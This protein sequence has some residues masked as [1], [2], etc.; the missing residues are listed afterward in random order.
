MSTT[1]PPGEIQTPSYDA[2]AM[3]EGTTVLS[4]SQTSALVAPTALSANSGSAQLTRRSLPGP[5]RL[6][7]LN[8]ALTN[9]QPKWYQW[10]GA[11]LT[12]VILMATAVA[13]LIVTLP[14]ATITLGGSLLLTAAIGSA[15]IS[16]PHSI[17]WSDYEALLKQYTSPQDIAWIRSQIQ[18]TADPGEKERLREFLAE[19]EKIEPSPP[20]VQDTMSTLR[21]Q[22]ANMSSNTPPSQE[23]IA[24]MQATLRQLEQR[25]GQGLQR[26]T[27]TVP[28]QLAIAS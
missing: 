6:A 22:V 18:N 4:S 7:Q 26:A 5:A 17:L 24:Q 13:S 11:I 3:G 27:A 15:A 19:L 23:Q 1:P 9:A 20:R 25:V 21:Q 10:V 2:V 12:G 28:A 14:F 8:Q 16:W